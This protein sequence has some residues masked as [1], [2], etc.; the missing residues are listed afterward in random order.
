MELEDSAYTTLEKVDYYS[1]IKQGFKDCD[2]AILI[3]ATQEGPWI[4]NPE[5]MK[6]NAKV[7][8]EAG[9]ALDEVAKKS[10]KVL[11]IGDSSNTNALVCCKN[12]PSIPNKN[13]TA[14]SRLDH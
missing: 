10:V 3:G 7:F 6:R 2:V 5:D 11:T 9:K 13:F 12:A 8:I 4:K 1:D 14:L